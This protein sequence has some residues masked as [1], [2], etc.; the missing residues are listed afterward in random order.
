VSVLVLRFCALKL[1]RRHI[2]IVNGLFLRRVA[3]TGE[4]RLYNSGAGNR[5]WSI[6]T[7]G[8]RL[9]A[10][11]TGATPEPVSGHNNKLGVIPRARAHGT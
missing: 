10:L 4:W 9:P 1:V 6:N 2:Y 8:S 5:P 11:E 7:L 3:G